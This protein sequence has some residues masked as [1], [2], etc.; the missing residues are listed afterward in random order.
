[1]TAEEAGTAMAKLRT[2][3]G[4]SQPQLVDLA[5]AM[6]HLSNNTASTAKQVT[7]F[8][9]RAGTAGKSAGLSA[10]Q[11]AA[12]GAAMIATGAESEVAATSFNNMVKA[13]SRGASMTDRQISALQRLGFVSEDAQQYEKQ[14]TSVVEEESRRRIA[15]AE[16]ETS[17]L[18]RELDRRYRDQ[19]TSIQDNFDDQSSA[20]QESL[21]DREE[22]QIKSLQRQQDREIE[23]ARSRAEALGTSADEE[24]NA[25][26]DRYDE[27]IDLIRD[28]TQDE[29][30]VRQRADRDRL[31]SIRDNLDDQKEVE[32]NALKDRFETFKRE[33]DANKKAAIEAAKKAAEEVGKG[34]A[35]TLATNLQ[36]DAIG[37]ITDVFNRIRQ[38][39]AEQRLSVVSDLFGDEARALLPLIEN[40]DL[41]ANTL[42]L[43]GDK[44]QYAGSSQAEYLSR[45]ATTASQVQM[46]QNAFNVLSITLGEKFVPALTL[47]IQALNPV[48]NA[49]TWVLQNVPFAGE[50]IAVLV[51]AF[52]ALTAVLPGIASLVYLVGSLGGLAGVLGGLGAAIGAVIGVLKTFGLVI[53]AVFTGPVGWIALLVAAGV[54]IYAFRDQIGAVF[55][56]IG[57]AHV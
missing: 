13:L 38:L 14:L 11:T 44:S 55:Q 12:F 2:S 15:V 42:A 50:T 48:I 52:I 4:L 7:E 36:R 57:R 53:A 30:K 40:A 16:E 33:E 54:A 29:I 23:A 46:A 37:T 22:A 35:E 39:P 18:R 26:R 1:M 6:N 47:L 56:E 8:M 10:E 5:D 9:L 3:L 41:L 45:V 25:I 43:V 21:R 17:K 49:F 34:A 24:I 32:M 31:Q 51:S 19:L 20:F 27:R 28:N